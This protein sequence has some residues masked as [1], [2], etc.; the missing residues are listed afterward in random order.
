MAREVDFSDHPP[1]RERMRVRLNHFAYEFMTG[2]AGEA[3]VAALQLQIGIADA[4]EQQTNQSEAFG[5]LGAR[6]MAN[7]DNARVE[8]DRD[9]APIMPVRY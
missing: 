8:M 1:A 7:F 6:R 3:V 2:R 5:T 4:R 9:H